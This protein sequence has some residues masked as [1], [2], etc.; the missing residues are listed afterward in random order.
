MTFEDVFSKLKARFPQVEQQPTKPDPS[1]SVPAQSIVAVLRFLRD[2]CQFETLANLGATDFKQPP[3]LVVFYHPASYTHK[4]V[5]C[6]KVTLPREPGTV[7]VDSI[8]E[9]YKA[10]DW[11]ERETYD[12]FGIRFNNHPNLE[13][14]LLPDDWEG[15]PLLK[16]YVTPDYYNGMPVPLY[17]EEKA[18]ESKPASGETP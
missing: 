1:I 15:Y 4:L 2:E 5:V 8:Y 6:L 13:R 10:A 16:D 17:F 14:I 18:A 7:A 11:L 12:L 9:I 3:S